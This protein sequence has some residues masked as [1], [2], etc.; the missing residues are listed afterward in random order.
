M[1]SENGRHREAR[2][3]TQAPR[4][5]ADGMNASRFPASAGEGRGEAVPDM[6]Q[7]AMRREGPRLTLTLS[8]RAG[9]GND[10]A[11]LLRAL[12]T[13][14]VGVR[15]AGRLRV[16]RGTAVAA[17]SV[18]LL[19]GC[20]I[21]E[22]YVR[23]EVAMPAGWVGR[24]VGADAS[25]WPD[26]HW[27]RA[28]GDETLNG[29]IDDAQAG[30]PDLAAAAARVEQARASSRIAGAALYP[31]LTVDP[32]ATRAKSPGGRSG[33][34]YTVAARA[35]YELDVWGAN[36]YSAQAAQA[37]LAASRYDQEAVRLALLGD[38]TATYF[39]VVSL[40]DRLRTAE[41]NLANARRVLQLIEV[42][43][44][45]GAVSGLEVERQRTL[46]A[47]AAAAIPPLLQSRQVARDALALLLGR[48]PA[49]VAL[50]GGSLQK[51]SA[52]EVP[53]G[54]PAQ[55]L[56]RRPDIRRAEADL[57]AANADIGAARA[58]LF[59]RFD[60][61]LRGGS[62]AGTLGRLF[63][64]GTGFYALG[65]DILATIF[66][67]GRLAGQVD[68]ARALKEELVANYRRSVLA[69]LRDTEDALAGIEQ[70]ALQEK[71]Q[72]EVI[73]HA[74]AA[75]DLAETRYK[76]GADDYLSVLD[77]QRTLLVAQAQLDPIRLARY[78]AIV[79]LYRALG[80]GW[81]EPAPQA[82]G[83]TQALASAGR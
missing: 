52:P 37:S 19:A 69:A 13:P 23:P 75:F 82:G 54:L 3:G 43:K 66:D 11:A 48:S 10:P 42:Q 39:E 63:E 65:L 50:A 1:K 38:V 70:F 53:L 78:V 32:S 45:A 16:L 74:R 40:N 41:D 67:G 35:S 81:Q 7:G 9:R 18:A 47:Q 55:L 29:L 73:A 22:K 72:Q 36:R 34:L 79:D 14:G 49:E 4:R 59:P 46:V 28:F 31:T 6:A 33:D 20:A 57:I 56:E 21:G 25:A 17:L 26:P 76:A 77:A 51:V 12:G 60:L 62:A 68:L 27:W 30:S 44:A 2:A 8:Q 24:G 5:Q 64:G 15:L 80:G 58:A 61:S 71:A 83:G